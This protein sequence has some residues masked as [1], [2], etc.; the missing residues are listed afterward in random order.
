MLKLSQDQWEEL[1]ARDTHQFV[2]A[3]CNQFLANRPDMLERLGGAAVQDSMQ[4]AYD[5]AVS[6][7]F[8]STPHIVR[9]LYLAAD[10]PGIHAAPLINAYLRKLGATPEQRLDD[11]IAVMN[12][13]LERGP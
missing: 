7:G 2:V 11:M 4:A 1:Q 12:N 10:A 9:L 5:Y 3:V 6:I 13:K 8:T